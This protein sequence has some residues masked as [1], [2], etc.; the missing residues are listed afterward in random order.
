MHAFLI[1]LPGIFYLKSS[2]IHHF[3][4]ELPDTNKREFYNGWEILHSQDSEC[5]T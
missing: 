4:I 1:V 2:T 3:K 5:L